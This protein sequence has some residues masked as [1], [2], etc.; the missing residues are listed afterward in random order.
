MFNKAS[1]GNRSNGPSENDS[2]SKDNKSIEDDL[3]NDEPLLLFKSSSFLDFFDFDFF[4]NSLPFAFLGGIF[5]IFYVCYFTIIAVWG[6]FQLK[7]IP[8]QR[9]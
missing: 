7:S 6:V 2:D 3:G 1:V 8:H 5:C 9:Q 4:C